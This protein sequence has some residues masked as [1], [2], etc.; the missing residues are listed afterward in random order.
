M[1]QKTSVLSVL[2]VLLIFFFCTETG[3]AVNYRCADLLEQELT[4][5]EVQLALAK[6]GYYEG[7]IDGKY[8][9]KTIS[10]ISSFQKASGLA[11]DGQV[12]YHLWVKLAQMTEIKEIKTVTPKFSPP[13]GEISI[14]ID[15]FRRKLIIMNNA[16]PYAQFPIAI[17]KSETPSP[18]GTWKIINKTINWGNGFGTRWMGLNVPWGIYGI[19]GTNKPWSIG[20]LAS[21]GCFRMF[22]KDVETIFPW[23]KHGTTVYVVGNPFSYMSGGVQRLHVGVKCSAVIYVQEKLIQKGFYQGHADGIFGPDTEKAVKKLQEHFQLEITG[24]IGD[25]EYAVLGLSLK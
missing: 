1:R 19:H 13:D 22:N 18:L 3:Y 9:E 23:I 15:T 5:E 8:D 25:Q 6:L 20:S 4:M 16:K 14:I 12:K 24:Q 10:A 11:I 17:G 2:L 21:H 7:V